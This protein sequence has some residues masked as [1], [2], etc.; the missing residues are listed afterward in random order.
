[1]QSKAGGEG[2]GEEDDEEEDPSVV[3]L[4]KMV[5]FSYVFHESTL[6]RRVLSD[7]SSPML[8]AVGER[9]PEE[10]ELL[11]A[12]ELRIKE[13]E[14]LLREKEERARLKALREAEEEEEDEEDEEEEEEEEEE[15]GE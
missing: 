6:A 5:G 13:I 11:L 2:G 1:M 12:E 7:L 9:A 10:E 4:Q 3:A 15:D 8:T 14:R